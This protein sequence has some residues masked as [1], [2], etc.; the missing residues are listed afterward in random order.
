MPKSSISAEPPSAS[1][2]RAE[3]AAVAIIETANVTCNAV[4][5]LPN[6]DTWVGATVGLFVRHT[7]GSTEAFSTILG[8]TLG[9]VTGLIVDREGDLWVSSGG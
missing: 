8:R 2:D 5:I 7:D 9:S 4:A 6:G 1:H 3:N